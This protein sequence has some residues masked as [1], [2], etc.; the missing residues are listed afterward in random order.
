MTPEENGRGPAQNPAG[1]AWPPPERYPAEGGRQR[2]D[3]NPTGGAWQRPEQ[4]PAGGAWQPPGQDRDPNPTTTTT[5]PEEI[6]AAWGLWLAT[7]FFALVGMLVNALTARF[8]D[9]PVATQDAL[10][11]AVEDANSATGGEGQQISVDLA[12]GL[13]TGLGAVLAVLVAAVTVWL[14]YRLRAGKGWAR[15]ILTIVAVFPIVDA[16]AVIIGVVGGAEVAGGRDDVLGFVVVAFQVLA[17][18]C[19]ATAVWRQHTPEAMEYLTAGGG[20]RASK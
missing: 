12:F 16:I 17:G 5:P 8:T 6:R 10:R 7:A 20:R 19:A 15:L 9:L 1:G 11:N 18:L 4:N 13:A 3:Q 2:P 14:A